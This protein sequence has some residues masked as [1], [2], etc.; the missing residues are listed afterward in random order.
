M[1]MA[2]VA[3]GVQ[4]SVFC[5]P[6]NELPLWNDVCSAVKEINYLNVNVN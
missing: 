5:G 3:F 2:C 1:L 6:N 4:H